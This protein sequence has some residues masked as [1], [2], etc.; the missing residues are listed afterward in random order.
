MNKPNFDAMEYIW[1]RL[2]KEQD[3]QTVRYQPND[4]PYLYHY[5]FVDTTKFTYLQWKQAFENFKQPD[6]TYLL[7]KKQF[8]SLRVFRYVATD[9]TPFDPH[10]LRLGVW[11]DKELDFLFEKSIKPSCHLP[12][13]IYLNSIQSLKK[14]GNA[15]PEGHLILNDAVIKQL[16]YLVEKFPT[17]RR[18][19]EKEVTRL[20]EEKEKIYQGHLSNRNESKFTIGETQS[21]HQF[22][23][24]KKLESTHHIATSEEAVDEE[25]LVDLKSL[26]NKARKPNKFIG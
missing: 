4:I 22:E 1:E 16:Q 21:E 23:T 11:P 8:M 12:K 26:K 15:T 19:L 17:P 2:P 6:D 24:L 7:N 20:R 5:G 10:K 9:Y 3:R 18:R 14:S 13:E 25:N